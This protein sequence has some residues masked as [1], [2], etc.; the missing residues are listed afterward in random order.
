M[1]TSQIIK[2]RENVDIKSISEHRD[3]Y[4]ELVS[5]WD[6]K[7]IDEE[8]YLQ[9]LEQLYNE[10][11]ILRPTNNKL[12]NKVKKSIKEIVGNDFDDDELFLNEIVYDTG[13]SKEL[14]DLLQSYIPQGLN[15][16]F[17]SNQNDLNH[18]FIK[19]CLGSF[20]KKS[21]NYTVYYDFTD[22]QQ[23]IEYDRKLQNSI[24]VSNTIRIQSLNDEE[25][26]V[27]SF[28]KLFEGNC[29]LVFTTMCGLHNVSG[30]VI[31]CIHSYANDVTTNYTK[32]NSLDL[33]VLTTSMKTITLYPISAKYLAN[34]IKNI[35]AT[36]HTPPVSIEIANKRGNSKILTS[37]LNKEKRK[38]MKKTK[39][40]KPTNAD[41]KANINSFNAMMGTGSFGESKRIDNC[42]LKMSR[43]DFNSAFTF[44][45]DEEPDVSWLT[46]NYGVEINTTD[47]K[48]TIRGTEED[49]DRLYDDFH[50]DDYDYIER[51]CG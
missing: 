34:K 10:I 29:F 27:K 2:L 31:L 39:V 16:E 17:L 14:Y 18:H 15:E 40:R 37:S 43:S 12:L 13:S 49:I 3:A 21:T 19:H 36:Y 48:A 22:I 44:E 25:L 32:G 20:D 51:N 7:E 42:I 8:T 50:L 38:S 23:Y 47:H 33:I 46:K 11:V 5:K 41:V 9:Q 35:F 4:N 6:K 30:D 24:G 1:K 26:V 45:G 28:N